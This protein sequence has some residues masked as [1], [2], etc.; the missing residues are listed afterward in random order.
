MIRKLISAALLIQLFTISWASFANDF[1]LQ[2]T[3]LL[4]KN[5]ELHIEIN[6]N[7]I[8]KNSDVISLIHIDGTVHHFEV[9]KYYVDKLGSLII[10][11]DE[12][13]GQS[14]N[15]LSLVIVDGLVNGKMTIDDITY[16]IEYND[17]NDAYA[18]EI[19]NY[20]ELPPDGEPIDRGK[21]DI[22]VQDS[23][24]LNST[25][26]AKS[27]AVIRVLVLYTP[28]AAASIPNTTVHASAQISD[29]NKVFEKS[30]L[31]NISIEPAHVAT[32][33]NYPISSV[34]A[35]DHLDYIETSSYA[36]SLRNQ[37]HADLVAIIVSRQ[38][39]SKQ[40]NK[41]QGVCGLGNTDVD[42]SSAF[43]LTRVTCEN[44]TFVH[45]IGHNLGA[46]HN[47][48]NANQVHYS[49]AH[50]YRN[51]SNNYRTVMAYDSESECCDR[52]PYWSS[53]TNTRNGLPL[54]QPGVNENDK[55]MELRAPV[56]SQF[57]PPYPDTTP[58][59]N[60]TTDY[61]R[62]LGTANWSS[63]DG[64]TS[65]ELL[66]SDYSDMSYSYTAYSGSETSHRYNIDKDKHLAVRACDSDGCGELSLSKW[67]QYYIPCR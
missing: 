38:E 18:L 60:I 49:Y 48:L 9:E 15:S 44:Y 34:V 20:N 29:A 37:Y 23:L 39:S 56:V 22:T 25:M 2:P 58:S 10:R 47:P 19:K 11:A 28:D 40:T 50:G 31:S 59:L 66:V 17:T 42:E 46:A 41:D 64:A 53:S 7:P 57:R 13:S 27:Y 62:G 52:I 54:G 67:A 30:G 3:Q 6:L 24:A 36:D 61:C 55:L 4:S 8:T 1:F 26:S 35:N 51:S 14:L 32:Y 45:E 12:K 21:N 16:G 63:V 33:V 65:Y 43:S 5:E